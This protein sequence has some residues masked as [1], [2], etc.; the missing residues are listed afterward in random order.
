MNIT[1]IIKTSAA[2][3]A[4]ISALFAGAF[5]VAGDAIVPA[6]RAWVIAQNQP[7]ATG[8]K[9]IARSILNFSIDQE[10]GKREAAERERDRLEL[11]ALKASDDLERT[12][13]LQLKRKA[14]DTVTKLN[15][16]IRTLEAQR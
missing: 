5:A 11:D 4:M 1:E 7:L 16:K 8:Q 13:V 15:D 10:T 12:K 9:D 14:D 3:V 6:M 2:A